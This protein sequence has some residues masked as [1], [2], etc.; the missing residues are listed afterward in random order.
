VLLRG[1]VTYKSACRRVSRHRFKTPADTNES[2]LPEA[3]HEGLAMPTG[4]R[5]VI[6]SAAI[7][8]VHVSV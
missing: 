6:G 3:N 7:I 5:R 4:G 1:L 2:L 8:L